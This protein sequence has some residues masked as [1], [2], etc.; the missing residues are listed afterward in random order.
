MLTQRAKHMDSP[1][2]APVPAG[3][4]IKGKLLAS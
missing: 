2:V 4:I 3:D 1:K